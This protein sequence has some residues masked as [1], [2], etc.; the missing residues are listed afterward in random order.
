MST[1]YTRLAFWAIGLAFVLVLVLP[2]ALTRTTL[3]GVSFD[4]TGQI[5]DTIGGL[6]APV[7]GLVSAVL[8][9]L[10]LSA[11][12][13]A[14]RLVK[15][16]F[17]EQRRQSRHERLRGYLLQQ[18]QLVRDEIDRFTLTSQT[19]RTT[20]KEKTSEVI[21]YSGVEAIQEALVFLAMHHDSKGVRVEVHPELVRIKAILERL[22]AI[23][24]DRRLSDLNQEEREFLMGSTDFTYRSSLFPILSRLEAH[25]TGL[26]EPC[27][28]HG[29]V[30]EGIPEDLYRLYDRL[31]QILGI[32]K[33][34][35][36]E[37]PIS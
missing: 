7:I 3:T 13:E 26:K 18:A 33:R 27:T 20:G 17:E 21:Q 9:Y 25:R 15:D 6:T 24:S 35:V 32:E 30:H 12:V 14:N 19:T 2:F 22:I 1:N 29:V 5:G 16:Q 8:L 34:S 36:I 10:A 28:E 4:G 23:V 37:D 11:Q 31:N